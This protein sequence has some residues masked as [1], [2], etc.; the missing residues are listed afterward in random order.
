MQRRNFYQFVIPSIGAAV[1]TSLYFV[2]DGI[3]VGNGV[4]AMA[5]ACIN[6]AV[7]FICLISAVDM[8]ITMGGATLT[9]IHFGRGDVAKANAT[10]RLTMAMV[11]TV[12]L[13]MMVVSSLFAPQLARLMG[14]SEMLV[15]GTAEYLRF[16]VMF[17]IFFS[18]SMM[19]AA[20]VRNDGNPRLAFWG[21]IVGA[22]S[23]V[24]LDWLFIFPLQMG[25]KGAAIA[26]GLGQVMACLVL[27]THFLTKRGDL[28]LGLPRVHFHTM[29]QIVKTGAPEF[30]TQMSQP[31]LIF[32]YNY[33]VIRIL[34]E[35]GVAA[36]SVVSYIVV[37]V[38]GIFIGL[39][40]GLQPLMSFSHG[41]GDTMAQQHYFRKGLRVNVTLA[42]IC[43][44]VLFVF[45]RQIIAVFNDDPAL[46]EMAY[47]C[48]RVYGLCFLFAAANIVFTIYNLSTQRT[49]QALIIAGLRSFVASVFFIFLMPAIF[50]D[51]AL[52]TGIVVAEAAVLVVAIAIGG[53]GRKREKAKVK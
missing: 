5:L 2:V 47:D 41:A 6:L 12:A 14:A 28:R 34:G 31:V 52:W 22:L 1:V 19:L 9:A 27:S 38:V 36:F 48:V 33:L 3:F 7:P 43:Y 13:T 15:P 4:G 46:I 30:I 44:G 35:M 24:A 37:I 8:M 39:G 53:P 40:E 51:G 17:A 32:C 20:F 21:M 23:N 45:G 42:A 49:K 50:G 10:F 26:S 18:S 25:I 11:I 29:R 16:Y